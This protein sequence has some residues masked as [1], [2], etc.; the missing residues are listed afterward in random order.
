MLIFLYA[1]I[2]ITIHAGTVYW[3]CFG[4]YCL[5]KLLEVLYEE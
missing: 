1:Y 5:K 2:G 3:V 4:L